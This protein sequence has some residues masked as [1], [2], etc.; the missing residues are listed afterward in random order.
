MTVRPERAQGLGRGLAA[1]IPQRP[2]TQQGVIELPIARIR[3]NPYQPRQRMDEAELATLTADWFA[4]A[5]A[6][7]RLLGQG[8]T[9]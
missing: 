8:R 3:P 5:D 6:M 1:L 4:F 7:A 2:T 9:R